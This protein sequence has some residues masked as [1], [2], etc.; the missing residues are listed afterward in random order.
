[1]NLFVYILKPDDKYF[2]SVKVS[3]YRKQFKCN[4]L[5]IKIYF[6]HFSLHFQNLHKIWNTFKEKMSLRGYLF[7]NL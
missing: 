5:K 1:M 4:Y 7:L 6:I 3:V 2:L